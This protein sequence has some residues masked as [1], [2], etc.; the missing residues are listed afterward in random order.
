MQTVSGGKGDKVAASQG[1]YSTRGCQSERSRV[2]WEVVVLVVWCECAKEW[3]KRR[4]SSFRK[5]Q[6]RKRLANRSK[7]RKQLVMSRE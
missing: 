5:R 2:V 7:S 3:H 4:S 1:L 6:K